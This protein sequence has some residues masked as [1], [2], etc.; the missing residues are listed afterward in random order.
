VP[1]AR[2]KLISL[3]SEGRKLGSFTTFEEACQALPPLEETLHF[4]DDSAWHGAQASV[5]AET[6]MAR[7][8]RPW[9]DLVRAKLDQGSGDMTPERVGRAWF[10]LTNSYNSDG[11]WPPTLPDAPHIVH[12]FNYCY[13]LENL[14]QAELIVGGVDRCQLDT[15]PVTTL[16]AI[17]GPQQDLV[18]A[19]AQSMSAS[20]DAEEREK[21]RRAL[22]MIDASRDVRRLEASGVKILYPA[23]YTVRAQSLIEA[24]R[25][26]GGVEIEKVSQGLKR[27]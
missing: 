4:D 5:W 27:T 3:I 17:L 19:K 24:R 7:L 12:P 8:L 21:G 9:Q 20:D 10:H 16:K 13:C 15:D 6:P 11:Q 23:E 2:G 1:T 26:V 14:L 25:L 22:Q 18:A